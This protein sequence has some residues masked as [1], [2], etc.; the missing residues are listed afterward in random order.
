M[1][2]AEKFMELRA[3]NATPPENIQKLKQRIEAAT[4]AMELEAQKGHMPS[5]EIVYAVVSMKRQLD[6][7][8]LE[9]AVSQV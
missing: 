5:D 9:W 2:V 6:G 7:L 3:K 1:S 8:Y 4:T